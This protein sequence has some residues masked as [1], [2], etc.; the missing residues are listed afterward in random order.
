MAVCAQCQV[1]LTLAGTVC[2]I[3]G[4]VWQHGH[5]RTAGVRVPLPGGDDTQP[6]H[7]SRIIRSTALWP[8][9]HLDKHGKGSFRRTWMI[10]FFPS[11]SGPT[12]IFTF[13]QKITVCHVISQIDSM[14]IGLWDI[15]VNHLKQKTGTFVAMTGFILV[16]SYSALAALC[17]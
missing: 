6:C 16:Q 5:L 14:L 3:W 2:S 1:P 15:I 4:A 12:D 11:S 8:C 17:V 10:L 13:C 7:P 9:L